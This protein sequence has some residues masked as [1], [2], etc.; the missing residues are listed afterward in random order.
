MDLN[1]I[2]LEHHIIAE[3]ITE[4]VVV[5][6]IRDA[7]DTIAEANYHGA[8][9]I[10]L[11]TGNLHRDF[12]NLRTG[13]A[14]GLLQKCANY[15]MRLAV[16]GEVEQFSSSSNSFNAFVLECNRGNSVFFVPDRDT[17]IARLIR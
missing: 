12:F 11:Q 6:N 3:V 13:L 2:E 9:S 5:N 16:V 4:E 15:R 1:I 17:A 8:H 14:G 10:I 7:L